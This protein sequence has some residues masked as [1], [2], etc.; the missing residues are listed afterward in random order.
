MGVRIIG[1]GQAAGGDDGVGLAVVEW[2]RRRG[3]PDGVE[4]HI[5]PEPSALLP[6]LE[7][8]APV[9]VVDAAL[10]APAGQVLELGP[11]ALASQAATPVSSHGLSVFQAIALARLISPGAVSPSIRV[12]AVTIARPE[13]YG[14]GL[15]PP[16]A[17]AVPRAAERI[18]TLT[19]G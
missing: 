12:V 10:G 19:G 13:R 11:E 7:G 16:V 6:L 18:L 2:L 1:L 8:G 9:V 17:E 15:S 5:A 3:V 4:L 14:H